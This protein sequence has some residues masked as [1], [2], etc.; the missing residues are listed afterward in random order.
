RPAI[1]IAATRGAVA[2]AA[3]GAAGRISAA[4][5]VAAVAAAGPA[6]AVRVASSLPAGSARRTAPW[7]G[8]P[9]LCV[10]V[11]LTRGEHELLAAI[12]ASQVLVVV[13]ETKTPLGS[14]AIPSG[15]RVSRERSPSRR[16]ATSVLAANASAA[17]PRGS[18]DDRR[19]T[20]TG[21]FSLIRTVCANA[22]PARSSLPPP[23]P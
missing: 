14:R 6:A 16:R 22:R 8:E 23:P 3:V 4:G 15:S 19:R 20:C 7:V 13:H 12:G 17:F 2:T 21:V 1:A 9:A 5:A 18:L 10:E 11:L